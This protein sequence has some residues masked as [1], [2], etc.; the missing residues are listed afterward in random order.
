ML[1]HGLYLACPVS[2]P[3]AACLLVQVMNVTDVDDKIILRARRNHLLDEYKRSA[4]A[5]EVRP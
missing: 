3:T 4:T 1:E 5:A 2:G